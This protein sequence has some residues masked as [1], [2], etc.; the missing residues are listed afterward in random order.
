VSLRQRQRKIAAD[1]GM[2]PADG[3]FELTLV[4]RRGLRCFEGSA[5]RQL[6]DSI[7]DSELLVEPV[8][9]LVS[10]A[11]SCMPLT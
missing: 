7:R 9:Q 4:E 8:S 1:E 10:I 11:R 3:T 2:E 5:E 6:L